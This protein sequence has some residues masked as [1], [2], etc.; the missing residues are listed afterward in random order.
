MPTV[1]RAE[2]FDIKIHFNDH[3]PAHVHA[4][5]AGGEAIII[6]EPLTI[7]RFWRMNR[8]DAAKAKSLVQEKRS[9]LLGSWEGIHGEQ[10]L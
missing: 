1:L 8:R 5:K 6:L 9:F 2:G 3:A 4:L 7:L 10:R